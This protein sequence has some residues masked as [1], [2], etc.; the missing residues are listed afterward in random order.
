M[1][2]GMGFCE[3]ADESSCQ[4]AIDGLNGHDFNGRQLRVDHA[5][6]D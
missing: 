2:V 1:L 3:F 4:A 5:K 6:R